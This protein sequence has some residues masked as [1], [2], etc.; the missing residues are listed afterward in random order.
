M[1]DYRYFNVLAVSDEEENFQGPL[2]VG[3]RREVGNLVHREA[4][5]EQE[6]EHPSH[7][8]IIVLETNQDHRRQTF[9]ASR[10]TTN[11][12][13]YQS[14]GGEQRLNRSMEMVSRATLTVGGLATNSSLQSVECH[15]TKK[16]LRT[17]LIIDKVMAILREEEDCT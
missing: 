6:R 2:T 16:R 1:P 7:E 8:A 17:L 10:Y 12:N 3:V 4:V 9:D 11:E 15:N 13:H 5:V 14:A